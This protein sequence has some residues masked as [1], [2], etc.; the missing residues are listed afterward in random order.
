[1][2]RPYTLHAPS[3]ARHDDMPPMSRHG[4]RTCEH[5]PCTR[6]IRLWLATRTTIDLITRKRRCSYDYDF[7]HNACVVSD[8]L[9]TS[10]WPRWSM[11]MEPSDQWTRI[12]TIRLTHD[13]RRCDH[14]VH[15]TPLLYHERDEA[16]GTCSRAHD[17]LHDHENVQRVSETSYRARV[18]ASTSDQ[19]EPWWRNDYWR[20]TTDLKMNVKHPI[21]R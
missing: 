1:M 13:D 8:H 3:Q 6:I 2:W 18:F 14:Q 21:W 16:D 7:E 5:D 10:N 9:R 15:T 17:V 4:T 11:I 12:M 19:S 20:L